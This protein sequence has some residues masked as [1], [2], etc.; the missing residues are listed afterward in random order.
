MAAK[1][2]PGLDG[3]LEGYTKP[4]ITLY[5]RAFNVME[6]PVPCS[7]DV[8]ISPDQSNFI[9]KRKMPGKRPKKKTKYVWEFL[10]YEILNRVFKGYRHITRGRISVPE[11]I[12]VL[13]ND[14]KLVTEFIPGFIL[15]RFNNRP[16]T[17]G[18]TVENDILT[19]NGQARGEVIV[20]Y[21]IAYHL[22]IL[23]R[24]KELEGIYHSDFDARHVIFNPQT[25]GI[26]MFDLENARYCPD[27]RYIRGESAKMMEE[28]TEIAKK[29]GADPAE[30]MVF[31]S[32]G[33][34][35]VDDARKTAKRLPPT[36]REM[37]RQVADEFGIHM[38]VTKGKLNRKEVG[39]SHMDHGL[40]KLV[41]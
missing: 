22:G 4:G 37:A 38:S 27:I 21:S 40:L 25:R 28:W 1:G 11:S 13:P 34:E 8:R 17:E 15:R 6:S 9:E 16:E 26:S 7:S 32:L 30:L 33:R 36:Y 14:Y 20:E 23:T 10:Q 41:E 29:R 19:L 3:L 2:K 12:A 5:F 39:I 35:V 18:M 24:I 31:Y